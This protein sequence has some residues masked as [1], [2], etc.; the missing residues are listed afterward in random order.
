MELSYWCQD[1]T[2]AP[3]VT[4]GAMQQQEIPSELYGV[5][6]A[7]LLR[8]A[9]LG[10]DIQDRLSYLGFHLP[11]SPFRVVQYT[12]D[13][14]IFR[15]LAGRHRHNCRLNMYSSLRAHLVE[16]LHEI[17]GGMFVLLMGYLFGILYT[18]DQDE[19]VTSVC[20]GA[21]DYAEKTLGFDVHVTVSDQLEGIE[22]IQTCY[23][24]IQDLEKSRAFYGEKIPRAFLIP[25]DALARISD[26]KQRTQ[27]EQT[28]FQSSERIC[29]SVRAGDVETARQHIQAQ[30]EKIAD[31]SIGMPYPTTLDL[32]TNRFISLLQYRLAEQDL[33]DWRYISQ[34]DFSRELV[35]Q[36]RMDEYLAMSRGI[37][38]LL[39]DHAKLRS[40]QRHDRLMR[41]IRT[42]VEAN[43]TDMNMGLT[44]VAREFKL[45]PREA[46]E[47]FRQYF[48]ESI[49]DVL[50]K[51]RVKKARELLLT[52]DDSVQDIAE[53]VGYCSL[54]TMYRAFTNVEGVAP[55]KLR[56]KKG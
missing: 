51:A 31:N 6:S 35:S 46:A 28:F 20:L 56:Q 10:H 29:G 8:G 4:V 22:K 39:V 32:T 21:A 38:Q 47:N 54:A 42:Y 30:L 37:A 3:I 12:L 55:G 33:A 13:D 19:L 11:E 43:A 16:S 40:E 26:A 44:A 49:N 41:D 17:P 23:M 2:E 5:V 18:G 1:A 45:K 50:H 24:T 52:T 48:G 14:P 15:E 36:K 25:K 53:A 7:L 34:I 9:E 27:F